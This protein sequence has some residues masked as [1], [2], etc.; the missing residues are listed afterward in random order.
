[1]FR[2]LRAEMVRQDVSIK[3]IAEAIGKTERVTYLRM[4][5][6]IALKHEEAKKIA[7]LFSENNTIE[8][9]FHK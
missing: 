9:L 7:A 5:G 8:Y 1:M 4:N 2:N 3:Q 6:K